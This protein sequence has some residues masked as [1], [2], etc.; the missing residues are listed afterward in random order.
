[1]NKGGGGKREEV[2]V[3]LFIIGY[4]APSICNKLATKRLPNVQRQKRMR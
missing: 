1:M 3:F 2:S 4:H